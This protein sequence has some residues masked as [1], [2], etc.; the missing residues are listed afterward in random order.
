LPVLSPIFTSCTSM[1]SSVA[2]YRFV[3]GVLWGSA[4]GPRRPDGIAAV[5][6]DGRQIVVLVAIA[7]AQAGP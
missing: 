1:P 7:V 3:I 5:G 2:R 6:Q 4:D